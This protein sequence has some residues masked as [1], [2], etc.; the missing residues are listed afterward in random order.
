MAPVQGFLSGGLHTS[1]SGGPHSM[2]SSVAFPFAT[3]NMPSGPN[4]MPF[5]W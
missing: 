5:V 1:P 2:P 4:A 3:Y